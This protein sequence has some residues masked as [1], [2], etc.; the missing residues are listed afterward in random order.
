MEILGLIGIVSAATYVIAMIL[1][2][3]L[4]WKKPAN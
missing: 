1:C 2:L 4:L 3:R